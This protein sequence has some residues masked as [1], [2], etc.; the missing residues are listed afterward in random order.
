MTRHRLLI[1]ICIVL[2]ATGSADAQG[3]K[4]DYERAERLGGQV[5]DKV[6]KAKVTPH[7]LE[8]N[9]RFW[10]R[11]DLAEGKREFVLVD[12]EKGTREAAFDHAKLAAVLKEKLGKEV[13]A[14]R[15]PL[16]WIQ[17]A[18][19]GKAIRFNVDGKGWKF[20]LAGG[21]LAEAEPIKLPESRRL[22]NDRGRTARGASGSRGSGPRSPRRE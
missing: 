16:E 2:G 10:Y 12:A 4:A 22:E 15:L 18:D 17:F 3:T 20:E 9:A 21:S 5:R 7:W 13:P 1:A 6:F 11:N 8:G 19:E 14:D